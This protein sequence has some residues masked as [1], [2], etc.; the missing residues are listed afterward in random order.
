MSSAVSEL[1]DV[2]QQP[3]MMATAVTAHSSTIDL[4]FDDDARFQCMLGSPS[5]VV[6]EV[7]A[8]VFAVSGNLTT[9][10]ALHIA[11]MHHVHP[12]SVR[13]IGN[14]LYTRWQRGDAYTAAVSV[15]VARADLPLDDR[16]NSARRHL[17]D[18]RTRVVFNIDKHRRHLDVELDYVAADPRTYVYCDTSQPLHWR[19]V[20]VTVTSKASKKF[21]DGIRPCMSKVP[22]LNGSW[23]RTCHL[24]MTPQ[25]DPRL[26]ASVC[27]ELACLVREHMA[28]RVLFSTADKKEESK[29]ESHASVSGSFAAAAAAAPS[30]TLVEP[31][32]RRH[33]ELYFARERRL[34]LLTMASL[35]MV[36]V[37]SLLAAHQQIAPTSQ[38]ALHNALCKKCEIGFAMLRCSECGELRTCKAACQES[39]W[40]DTHRAVCPAY[41][42]RMRGAVQP[43]GG[44]AVP[45]R[46]PR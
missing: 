24:A 26:V 35:S 15:A 8:L 42:N 46:E 4:L 6:R 40:C 2:T 37:P 16:A 36:D 32:E 31:H 30:F 22:F 21:I 11:E 28:G 25:W 19:V 41:Q 7:E 1:S 18:H 23:L 45:K 27:L 9:T 20:V 17:I 34:V 13:K 39:D 5:E 3:R 33:V 43:P 29:D 14:E 12:D 44:M 38:K 10:Q